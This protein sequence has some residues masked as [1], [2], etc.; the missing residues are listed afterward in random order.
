MHATRCL[1]GSTQYFHTRITIKRQAGVI[2]VS[3]TLSNSYV[4]LINFISSDFFLYGSVSLLSVPIRWQL[5]K[6]G[7]ATK[8]VRQTW[9]SS[10]GPELL[11]LVCNAYL[12]LI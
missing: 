12:K 8:Q 10:F 9:T 6:N 3:Y 4:N 11:W 5:N 1:I 2:C 7:G